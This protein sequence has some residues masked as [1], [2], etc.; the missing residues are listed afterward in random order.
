MNSDIYYIKYL[1]YKTKYL[2]EKNRIEGGG[3]DPELETKIDNINSLQYFNDIICLMQSNNKESIIA[4]LKKRYETDVFSFLSYDKHCLAP[5][6][7]KYLEKKQKELE[8]YAV[9]ERCVF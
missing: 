6:L 7:L 8:E 5:E 1:K 4:F 3:C 2:E 9:L